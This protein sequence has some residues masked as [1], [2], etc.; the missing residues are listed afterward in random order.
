[1]T[2]KFTNIN[3]VGQKVMLVGTYERGCFDCQ[4]KDE[5]IDWSEYFTL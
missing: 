4:I 1:M 3:H 5:I 2:R